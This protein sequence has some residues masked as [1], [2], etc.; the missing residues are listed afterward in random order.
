GE[1]D[2]PSNHNN[3]SLGPHFAQPQYNP[4]RMPELPEVEVTRRAFASQ[5]AGARI[6]SVALG[7]P[8]RWPLGIAPELLTGREVHS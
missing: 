4:D 1:G 3:R 5:I 7:K 2:D 6:E 8:L